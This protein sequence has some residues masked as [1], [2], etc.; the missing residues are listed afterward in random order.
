MKREDLKVGQ[1]VFVHDTR[2]RE[3]KFE[4][5]TITK[6]GLK[7]FEVG[8]N[9]FHLDTGEL[10]TNYNSQMKVYLT[11]QEYFD[12]KEKLTLGIKISEKFRY[13]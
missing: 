5:A 10:V 13:R 9:K 12:M 2:Y 7:Y 6:V 1:T 3:S 11:E 8:Y 4:P